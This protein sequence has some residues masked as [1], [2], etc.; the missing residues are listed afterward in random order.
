MLG[1]RDVVQAL[2]DRG[3][4]VNSAKEDGATP[5][6]LA[7]QDGHRGGRG[8]LL[9]KGAQVNARDNNGITALMLASQGGQREVKKLLLRAG[10]K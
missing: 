8:L 1:N 3:A 5:L 7:A 4:E 10:A 2:L 6:M 9:A